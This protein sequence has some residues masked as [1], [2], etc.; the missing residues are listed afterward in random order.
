M[1]QLLDESLPHHSESP[2]VINTA[3]EP[4]A[5]SP[6]IAGV[7]AL[8]AGGTNAHVLVEEAPE[9]PDPAPSPRPAELLW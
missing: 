5:A 3:V 4:F 7:T 9:A 1:P 6:R 8:G 2:F